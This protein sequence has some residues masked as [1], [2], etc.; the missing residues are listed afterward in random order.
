MDKN[1]LLIKELRDSINNKIQEIRFT[2]FQKESYSD[3]TYE[4]WNRDCEWKVENIRMIYPRTNPYFIN[5][6]LSVDLKISEEQLIHFCGNNINSIIK[7]IDVRY[8]FPSMLINLR[9]NNFI[10]TILNDIEKALPWFNQYNRP[11]NCIDE[12]T[13]HRTHLRDINSKDYKLA[14]DFLNSIR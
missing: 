6:S 3:K 9:K 5:L 7:K 11:E 10:N 4:Q 14:M 13:G 2:D 12:L 1:R 8:Q